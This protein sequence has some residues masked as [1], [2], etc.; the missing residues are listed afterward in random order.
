MRTNTDTDQTHG[1]LM[2]HALMTRSTLQ[3]TSE[4]RIGLNRLVHDLRLP[5]VNIH[6]LIAGKV[7][8]MSTHAWTVAD[9]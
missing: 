7:L 3:S 2:K 9:Q 6:K 4:E 1:N 8:M 5:V